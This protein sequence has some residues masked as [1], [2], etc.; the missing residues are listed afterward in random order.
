[1]YLHRFAG[2]SGTKRDEAGASGWTGEAVGDLSVRFPVFGR[3]RRSELTFS[4]VSG[5]LTL[6][7]YACAAKRAQPV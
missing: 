2:P 5:L 6:S 7:H 1:M 3:Q 4:N